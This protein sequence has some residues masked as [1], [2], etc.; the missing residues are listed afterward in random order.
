MTIVLGGCAAPVAPGPSPPPSRSAP[1]A[2]AASPV[3]RPADA[4]GL[5]VAAGG[6]L[7]VS[8]AG[9]LEP[10]DGPAA[11]SVEV[12]AAGGVIVV[13]D[14]T[15]ALWVSG[16]S[17][18]TS[19]AW[20]PLPTSP[21]TPASSLVGLSPD[22]RT[23]AL[24]SGAMQARSFDLVLRDVGAGTERLIDVPRGLDGPPVW[25]GPDIVAAHAIRDD[26]TSGFTRIVVA[27]GEVADIPSY[28]V[29]LAATA[30]GATVAFDVATSGQVLVGARRDMNDA[31][32]DRMTRLSS[33]S[34]AGVER[35]ALSADGRRLA[36][37][38]RTDSGS[39]IELLVVADGA[40]RQVGSIEIPGDRAVS[41]A[42]LE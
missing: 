36:I 24:A 41:I 30:D 20:A 18:A 25:L 11:I 17:A 10:F 31:G 9:A 3:A 7:Q 33:P 2:T 22:G 4:D 12:V 15:R 27:T 5:L 34:G 32:L 42:W 26:Q 13:V 35:L 1:A 8:A 40:W 29:A 16:P 23:L 38:R 6:A 21:A 37:V 28:G 19:R 39:A 14:A